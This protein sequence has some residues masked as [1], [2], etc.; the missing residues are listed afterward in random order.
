[1]EPYAGLLILVVG[2]KTDPSSSVVLKDDSPKSIKVEISE[3]TVSL[4]K[5]VRLRV[6]KSALYLVNVLLPITL[7]QPAVGSLCLT[8]IIL[9]EASSGSAFLTY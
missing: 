3:R 7:L 1:M 5:L 8:V 2:T 6:Y 4:P 9:I